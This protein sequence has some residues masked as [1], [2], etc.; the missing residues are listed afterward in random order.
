[1]TLKFSAIFSTIVPTTHYLRL[2]TKTKSHQ[3]PASPQY[4]QLAASQ[5]I[6]TADLRLRMVRFGLTFSS[7]FGFAQQV[8]NS[9]QTPTKQLHP[10]SAEVNYPQFI[11]DN[12]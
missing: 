1:M 8:P 7:V 4:S 9:P 5:R 11:D 6:D 12:T 3:T 2:L 10:M